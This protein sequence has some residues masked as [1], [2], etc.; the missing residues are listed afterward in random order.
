MI[1]ILLLEDNPKAVVV[2]EEHLKKMNDLAQLAGHYPS[3]SDFL[4][5]EKSG[6]LS[7]NDFDVLFLD[8]ELEGSVSGYDFLKSR[9]TLAKPVVVVSSYPEKY[10]LDG[11]KHDVKDFLPKPIGPAD[12]KT[13]IL[14]LQATLP[15]KS[16]RTTGKLMIESG[17]DTLFFS[18]HDIILFESEKNYIQAFTLDCPPSYKRDETPKKFRKTMKELAEELPKGQFQQ[19]SRSYLIN[20]DYISSISPSEVW[21][22]FPLPNGSTGTFN[23]GLADKTL[24]NTFVEGVK[25]IFKR[26]K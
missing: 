26:Q 24:R 21:L 22:K 15:V 6:K 18:V 25:N 20:V 8:I 7:E 1:R 16:G 13:C 19:L 3:V 12:L 9:P 14:K 10:S 2:L 17:K 5:A 11:Y 23:L 4:S